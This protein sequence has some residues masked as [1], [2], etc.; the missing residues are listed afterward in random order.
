M[1][2]D[3]LKVVAIFALVLCAARACIALFAWWADLDDSEWH[4]Q[5][6]L[7]PRRT[8]SGEK[9]SGYIWTR[10]CNGKREYM[11]MDQAKKDEFRL[12]SNW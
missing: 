12:R 7:F 5:H 10:V 1:A 11:K 3:L 8:I 4:A 9:D 2:L 6:V